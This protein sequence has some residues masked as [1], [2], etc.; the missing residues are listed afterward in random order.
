MINVTVEYNEENQYH[1]L[2]FTGDEED[3]DKL[4]VILSCMADTRPPRRG[5]FVPSDDGEALVVQVAD[6]S[7]AE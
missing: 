6:I 7:E 2:R 4:D 5:I 3:R 1:E